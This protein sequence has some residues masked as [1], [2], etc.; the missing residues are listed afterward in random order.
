MHIVFLFDYLPLSIF[1]FISNLCATARTTAICSSGQ[2]PANR[3]SSTG[4][5][6]NGHGRHDERYDGRRDGRHEEV[7]F[8]I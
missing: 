4:A 3:R 5:P 6:T 2:A 1:H 8:S 7:L